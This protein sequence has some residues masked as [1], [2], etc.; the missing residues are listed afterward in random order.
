[1]TGRK[2][3]DFFLL[4]PE[5][6][7]SNLECKIILIMREEYLAYLDR[8]EEIVPHLFDNRL[9]L[10]YMR[11]DQ[12][13]E[14][15]E[16]TADSPHVNVELG[17]PVIPLEIMDSVRDDQ[18][19]VDLAIL[20]V[21]LDRLF[22]NDLRRREAEEIDRP[23]RFDTSLIKE[24]GRIDDVLGFFLEEQLQQLDVE[25]KTNGMGGREVALN[26]LTELITEKETK[27]AM[28]VEELKVKPGTQEKKCPRNLS[29]CV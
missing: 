8:F 17:S 10:E 2:K 4:L 9:R 23:V 12:V 5:L 28:D 7:G 6:I 25:L 24:T 29:I 13:V 20:Q 22:R 26:V 16:R 27:Q 3:N 19:R 21:Y 1:M 18:G 11:R 15:I 14:V